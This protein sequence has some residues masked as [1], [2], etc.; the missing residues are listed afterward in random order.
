MTRERRKKKNFDVI[1]LRE[2]NYFEV[3]RYA[4]RSREQKII[5]MRHDMSFT[6]VVHEREM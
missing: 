5:S 1:Y 6:C 4:G 3:F 2:N